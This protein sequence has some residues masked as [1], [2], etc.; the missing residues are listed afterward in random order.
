MKKFIALMTALFAVIAIIFAY[1]VNSSP[2]IISSGETT[3]KEM[4]D[5]HIDIF[6]KLYMSF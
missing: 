6:H 4:P 1:V 2:R 3:A 5:T